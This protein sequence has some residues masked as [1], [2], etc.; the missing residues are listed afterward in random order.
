MAVL[1]RIWANDS[2]K[3]LRFIYDPQILGQNLN[4][5]TSLLAFCANL[6]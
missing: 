3:N 4:D 5:G 6:H 1:L 2:C